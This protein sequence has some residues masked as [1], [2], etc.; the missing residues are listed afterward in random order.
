MLLGIFK[1]IQLHYHANN[2]FS[3]CHFWLPSNNRKRISCISKFRVTSHSY[4]CN[5]LFLSI[6]IGNARHTCTHTS[7]RIK[8]TQKSRSTTR[9]ILNIK[10]LDHWRIAKPSSWWKRLRQRR[11]SFSTPLYKAIGRMIDWN[12]L[13]LGCHVTTTRDFHV[14]S[15]QNLVACVTRLSILSYWSIE[16]IQS[17][18]LKTFLSICVYNASC[19][20]ALALIR[21]NQMTKCHMGPHHWTSNCFQLPIWVGQHFQRPYEIHRK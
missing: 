7:Y 6:H 9:D 8:Y 4:L 21:H 16:F 5:T 15:P 20:V 1:L 17:H 2:L 18:I 14:N 3:I 19:I 10:P 13:A 11:Y 12:A